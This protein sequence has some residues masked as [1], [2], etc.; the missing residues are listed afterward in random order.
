MRSV[1][2]EY[3]KQRESA[4]LTLPLILGEICD[5]SMFKFIFVYNN[6]EITVFFF[7]LNKNSRN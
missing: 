6:P 3:V 5:S 7:I 2:K 1:N 4:G